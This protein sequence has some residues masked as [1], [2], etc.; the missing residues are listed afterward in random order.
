MGTALDA[1]KRLVDRFDQN[2]KVFLSSDHEEEQIRLTTAG[3]QAEVEEKPEVRKAGELRPARLT[4]ARRRTKIR[5]MSAQ[6]RP[7]LTKAVKMI[8]ASAL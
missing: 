6:G 2:R 4:S 1:I 3:H 5:P 7:A 8:Q